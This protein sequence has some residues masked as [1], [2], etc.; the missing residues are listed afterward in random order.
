MNFHGQINLHSNNLLRLRDFHD[1]DGGGDRTRNSNRSRNRNRNEDGDEE[2]EREGSVLMKEKRNVKEKEEEKEEER[3]KEKGV[4]GMSGSLDSNINI[5]SNGK[6]TAT[7]SFDLERGEDFGDNIS[8]SSIPYISSS[9]SSSS[10]SPTNK[11]QNTPKTKNRKQQQQQQHEKYYCQLKANTI[12]TPYHADFLYLC[13]YVQDYA[14]A[15]SFLA[16]HSPILSVSK[17]KEMGLI[18]EDYL[19]FFY[20]E[21]LLYCQLEEYGLAFES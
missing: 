7:E 3:E 21:G 19:R 16:N 2:G 4:F 13:L 6:R 15:L 10:L 12:L 1:L 5:N 17:C 9:S 18:S 11:A 14:Q 8:L 20:Y